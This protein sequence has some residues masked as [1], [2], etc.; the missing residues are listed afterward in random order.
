MPD[1]R[2]RAHRI[3]SFIVQFSFGS[4]SYGSRV[5]SS[6]KDAIPGGTN[7]KSG[8]LTSARE[9]IVSYSNDKPHFASVT[10]LER[11]REFTWVPDSKRHGFSI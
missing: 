7:K 9:T 1:S 8:F 5:D 3:G 10:A 4:G 6:D 11:I 2:I